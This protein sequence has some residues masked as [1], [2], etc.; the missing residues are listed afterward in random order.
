[1]QVTIL[2]LCWRAF[3]SLRQFFV[4]FPQGLLGVE[5]FTVP[6]SVTFCPCRSNRLK[7]WTECLLRE[8]RGKRGQDFPLG[9]NLSWFAAQTYWVFR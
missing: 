8:H 2:D 6:P 1:M 9:R 5:G 4:V 3:L 7:R